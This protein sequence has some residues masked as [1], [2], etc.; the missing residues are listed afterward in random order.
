MGSLYAKL[1]YSAAS[2]AQ[3]GFDAQF[4][5]PLKEGLKCRLCHLG[6]R[7]PV[8]TLCGHRFCRECIEDAIR[9]KGRTCPVSGCEHFLGSSEPYP[10]NFAKQEVLSWNVRCPLKRSD[11][12]NCPWKGPLHDFQWHLEKTCPF[13]LE[14]CDCGCEILRRD[15]Q[16]HVATGCPR[17]KDWRLEITGPKADGDEAS[18]LPYPTE[19]LGISSSPG[20]ITGIR[21]AVHHVEHQDAKE[22]TS[23]VKHHEKA[24]RKKSESQQGQ[25]QLDQQIDA[26]T[27]NGLPSCNKLESPLSHEKEQG[28]KKNLP[29]Q[30]ESGNKSNGLDLPAKPKVPLLYQEHD[31]GKANGLDVSVQKQ[32]EPLVHHKEDGTQANS[33]DPP[34]KP[35][36]ALAQGKEDGNKGNGLELPA[37]PSESLPF[38]GK[39]DIEANRLDVPFQKPK[40]PLLEPAATPKEQLVHNK[41]DGTEAN[42]LDPLGKPNEPLLC[43]KE[44]AIKANSLDPPAKANQPLLYQE[45]D[46]SETDGLKPLA[47]PNKPLLYQEDGIEG[48][49]LDPPAKP[50]K[51]LL[52]QVE[53]GSEA[54]G[55]KPLTKPNEPLLYQEEDGIEANGLDPPAKPNEPLAHQ[56]DDDEA[57]RLDPPDKPN[58]SL[59]YQKEDGAKPNGL[60]LLAKPKESLALEKDD[61]NEANGFNLPVK[62][63]VPSPCQE[64]EASGLV[65][66]SQNHVPSF[67]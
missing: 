25:L 21:R 45:G 31:G 5:P 47:K 13:V 59:V 23:S 20:Q 27:T 38:Q 26:S 19:E 64:E 9:S 22:L 14:K 35:K 40:V 12:H 53:D 29:H 54:D 39:D 3:P 15:L 58:E 30:K 52:C 42:G 10:D 57:N 62:P 8:Q 6:L 41:E 18:P 32:K 67:I 11:D 50:N 2:S 49:G 24:V 4:E 61:G 17:T 7:D 37:K 33:L 28:N 60:D 56:K 66:S 36:E 65:V 16:G 44:D 63:I 51:P 48:D 43:H 55:L 46:G 1:Y 34:A